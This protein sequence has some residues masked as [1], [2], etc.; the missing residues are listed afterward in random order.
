MPTFQDPKVTAA[1]VK[2]KAAQT[3]LTRLRTK[4]LQGEYIERQEVKDFVLG[5]V[6]ELRGELL[7]LPAKIRRAI[8]EAGEIKSGAALEDCIERAVHDWMRA[9]SQKPLPETPKPV[10]SRGAYTSKPGPHVV[11]TRKPTKKEAAE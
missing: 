1:T 6:Q 3:R 9:Y 5:L 10:R 11:S 7:N 8:K 2:L 4:H